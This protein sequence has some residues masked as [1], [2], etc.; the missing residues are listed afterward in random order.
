MLSDLII[1]HG[2]NKNARRLRS[3]STEDFVKIVVIV[4]FNRFKSIVENSIYSRLLIIKLFI[5]LY[6]LFLKK[7]LSKEQE[8]LFPY[9]L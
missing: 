7:V 8:Y 3:S 4:R 5:F 6:F 1:S 9:I 2:N